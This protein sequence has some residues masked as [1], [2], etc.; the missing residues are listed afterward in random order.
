MKRVAI[1]GL[2]KMGLLHASLLSTMPDVRLVAICEKSFPIRMFAS[3]VLKDVLMVGSVERLIDLGLDMVY[4]TTPPS[5]HYPIVKKIYGDRI[6]RHVFVE[7]PLAMNPA[8]SEELCGLAKNRGVNMVGYNRRFGVAF[9][10]AKEILDDGILGELQSFRVYAY[11]SDLLGVVKPP[12][13]MI[14]DGILRDLGCHAIDLAVWLFGSLEVGRAEVES[15][16]GD[17]RFTVRANG[18][19]G[20]IK[21]SWR[22]EG[23]RLPEVGLRVVG[24][25]GEMDVNE[26][27]VEL[28]L[29]KGKPSLWR[30]HDLDDSVPFFL[31]GAEY[32]REDEAFVRAVINGHDVKPDFQSA[33]EVDRII[34]EVE[35]RAK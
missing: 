32:Y 30:R 11:S 5:T 8:E 4:V 7:K 15:A 20:E 16:F 27:R 34:G 18:L 19:G 14:R 9:G 12:K 25:K 28:K 3:R 31:G 22:M 23:Y 17:T 10:K 29:K 13:P 24:S 21:S 26:D 33:L 1:V 2:G 35:R 6:A